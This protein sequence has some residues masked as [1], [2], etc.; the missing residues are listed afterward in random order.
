MI[1]IFVIVWLQC[2]IISFKVIFKMR[3]D[4]NEGSKCAVV[5][6]RSSGSKKVFD[7]VYV[8]YSKAASNQ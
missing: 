3:N 2:D 6:Q 8:S 1:K 5:L 7:H 4:L